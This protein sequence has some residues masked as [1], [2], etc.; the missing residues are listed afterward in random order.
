VPHFNYVGDSIIGYRGHLGAGVI[1]SNVKLDRG[2]IT[3]PTA[4]GLVPTGLK[5]FG[6]VIGDR[7][8]IGCNSVINPGSIIGRESI[9]YPGTVWRGVVPARSVVKTKQEHEIVARRD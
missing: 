7:A 6:A 1:L 8:E 2:E 4:E 5:K 3:V 9:I